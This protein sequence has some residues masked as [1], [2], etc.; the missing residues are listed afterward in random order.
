MNNILTLLE[1]KLSGWLTTF[2]VNLPNVLA[3]LVIF[4]VFYGLSALAKKV[5]KNTIARSGGHH[6]L[7]VLLSNISRFVVIATGL[8]V[9]LGILGLGKTVTAALAGAG[10]I[11]IVLGFAL[12]DIAANFISGIILIF[13]KP[14][15]ENDLIEVNDNLGIV[16]EINLRTTKIRL[17]TGQVL[18]IP[19]QDV[20]QNELTNYSELGERRVDI[21]CG[22]SYNDDLEEARK[23]AIAAV[24]S[25]EFT[26]ERRSV[27]VFY[28]QFAD[29]S[30][31]FKLRFWIDFN[32]QS[33]FLS[34]QS[35][36]I[37]A[38]KTAFQ[39]HDI[40]MPF[41]VRTIEFANNSKE[42]GLEN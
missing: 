37:E 2:S 16:R 29:S 42:K 25:L 12:Q 32:S 15:E 8:I 6:S 36:A 40:D 30:I 34:A 5:T 18:Y 10:V 20:F 22:V 39:E 33:D 28:D 27:E 19:N 17:P 11:G 24:N 26:S 31:N 23:V 35:K 13:R 3:A 21:A 1:Q 14:F 41:P 4:L 9:A 38:I 7:Q